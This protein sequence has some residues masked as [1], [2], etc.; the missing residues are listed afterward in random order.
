MKVN[1]TVS[2]ELLIPPSIV[3]STMTLYKPIV[4]TEGDNLRLR[5]V[6][7]GVPKPMIEW[8]KLD[9]SVIPLG[10]WKSINF[11]FGLICERNN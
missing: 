10:A 3:G 11:F 8:R 2:N 5:C 6:A 4:V 9:N 1:G 7:S